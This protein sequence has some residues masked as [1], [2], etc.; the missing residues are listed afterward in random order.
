MAN[1]AISLDATRSTSNGS[2]KSRMPTDIIF[3]PVWFHGHLEFLSFNVDHGG[4]SKRLSDVSCDSN[5]VRPL[6]WF[7][8]SIY[9]KHDSRRISLVG[10]KYEY[11]CEYKCEYS[12]NFQLL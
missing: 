10:N 1:L 12:F 7:G 9:I 6:T 4:R 8:R 5:A 11:S 2:D 3:S